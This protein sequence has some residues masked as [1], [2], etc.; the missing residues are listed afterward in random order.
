MAGF[1]SSI[2]TRPQSLDQAWVVLR[3]AV[4]A[5]KTKTTNLR[6]LAQ[7]GNISSSQIL[8]YAT[9]LA[10]AKDVINA[11][12]SVSGIDVYVKQQINDQTFDF[13]TTL[14][15]LL[16]QIAATT[17]WIVTNF[18]APNGFIAAKQFAPDASGRTVDRTFTPSQTAGFV[19][20]LNGL[21]G[22]ID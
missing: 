17:A 6:T 22:A 20:A 4:S 3:N 11:A 2:G 12:A 10:E 14:S 7:V 8:D 1:P 21:I 5:V 9:F 13:S 16:A 18:P 15:T 19:V